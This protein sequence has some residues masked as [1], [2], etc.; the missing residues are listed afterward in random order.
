MPPQQRSRG[1]RRSQTESALF[2]TGPG[3]SIGN[4]RLISMGKDTVRGLARSEFVSLRAKAKTLRIVV[5]IARMK[6]LL[7]DCC[8][9][10]AKSVVGLQISLI[11]YNFCS[12]LYSARSIKSLPLSF[13]NPLPPVAEVGPSS[14]EAIKKLPCIIELR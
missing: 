5:R 7:M 2:D 11:Q 8:G 14:N 10:P 6:E 13:G 4:Q 9:V 1:A 3:A 12:S